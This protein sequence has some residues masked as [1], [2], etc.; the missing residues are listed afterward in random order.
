[1]EHSTVTN[2]NVNSVNR[3]QTTGRNYG[4]QSV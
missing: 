4:R 3:T 1:M 2:I